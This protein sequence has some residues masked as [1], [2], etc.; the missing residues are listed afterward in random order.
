MFSRY[1]K[2]IAQAVAHTVSQA[3]A[4]AVAQAVDQAIDVIAAQTFQ[5]VA[6]VVAQVF[7]QGPFTNY[8][9]HFL[10]L[11]DH[12]PTY[13]YVFEAILLHIYLLEFAMVIFC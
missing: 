5:V 10:I 1:I 12:P 4:E 2:S 3:F 7:A 9:M 6:Y 8:V 13:A 11:F